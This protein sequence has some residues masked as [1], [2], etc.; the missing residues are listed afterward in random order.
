MTDASPDLM[1]SGIYE[2]RKSLFIDRV[3]GP[4]LK[5]SE[6]IIHH[7]LVSSHNGFRGH[8]GVMRG[9]NHI[10]KRK[11]RIAWRKRFLVINIQ[12]C[13]RQLSGPQSLD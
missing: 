9:K 3:N 5:E 6:Y 2:K 4:T 1:E 8:P 10:R 7:H 13:G 11:K 12:T